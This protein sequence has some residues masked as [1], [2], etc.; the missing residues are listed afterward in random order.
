MKRF[1]RKRSLVGLLVLNAVPLWGL[2]SLTSAPLLGVRQARADELEKANSS[3]IDLET[4]VRTLSNNFHETSPPESHLAERRLV[5]AQTQFEL[6][7]YSEAATLLFDVIERFPN[8]R[9]YDEALV[10]MGESLFASR[11]LLGAQRYFEKALEKKS[12]SRSEQQ[13]LQRLVEIALK[14][15]NLQGIDTYLE[16]LANI[17]TSV[18]EPS[19]PYV[20]GKYLFL[21]DKPDEA[22]AVFNAL[23]PSNPY[24]LQSRYLLATAYVKKGDLAAAATGFDN[25]LKLEP[26][27]AND[28]EVQE[29]A[30]IA[31]GRIYFDRGQLDQAKAMYVS[32]DRTSKH[33]GD[34][35]YESAW[36]AIKAGDY[37]TAY[38]ALDLLLLQDPDS[39]RAPE[40][41]LLMGNLNLRLSNFYVA[42]DTFGKTR[43]EFEPIYRE[44]VTQLDRSANDPA[45]FQ[46]LVGQDLG[47]FDISIF[48]PEGAVKWVRGEPEVERVLVLASDV[49]EIKRGID[50]SEELMRRLDAA[51]TGQGKVGIFPDLAEVRTE[52]S[53]VLNTTLDLRRRFV[54]KLRTMAGPYLGAEDKAA[55][56][57]NDDERGTLETQLKDLP[58]TA[59]ALKKRD[60]GTKGQLNTLDGRVSEINV[61]IQ[62]LEAELVAIEQYYQHSKTEQKVTPADV[63]RQADEVRRTISELRAKS[64][65]L[66]GQVEDAAR[67]NTAAGAAGEGE[68]YAVIRLSDL[69][70]EEAEIMRNARDKM[71]PGDQQNFDRMITILA[72]AD[73]VQRNV[74]AF[75]DRVDK[76]AEV[77]LATLREGLEAERGNLKSAEEK[78]TALTTE[79][80]DVGG[81]L[82]QTIVGRV[83]DRFYDVVV[84]SDVGLIDVAWGLKDDKTEKLSKLITQQKNELKAL[85]EDFRDI[86]EQ[87]Q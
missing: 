49:G 12:A 70:K 29:L 54:A 63:K 84:Q 24:Y 57:R 74:A 27:G 45:F 5:D 21:R 17:P 22:I 60:R 51:I 40:L 33:F 85:D 78:L 56:A 79:S 44:L 37:K 19:V 73:E 8:T 35:M 15:G 62:G 87:E 4:R 61:L 6:R 75:D 66:R 76:A 20:R 36:T 86:L 46:N 7:N 25:V 64:D 9:V 50:E 69:I 77:R 59:E 52:S 11:D 26:K 32:V 16:R 55:L 2:L 68:R 80:Q 38:R 28:Q 82:A 43:E 72:R 18:L 14:T 31:L 10:L 3:L 48:V 23:A 81:G 30:R 34:A 58:L 83:K 42:S 47:K 65:V 13:A 67:Q 71:P 41:R 53:E 1:A 39:P